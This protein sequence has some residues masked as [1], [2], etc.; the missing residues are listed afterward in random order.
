MKYEEKGVK[1]LQDRQIVIVQGKNGTFHQNHCCFP[2]QT[3]TDSEDP[4]AFHEKTPQYEIHI[5]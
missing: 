2:L 5:D 4:D 3:Q 1:S